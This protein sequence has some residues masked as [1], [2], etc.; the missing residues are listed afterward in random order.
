MITMP[1][2]TAGKTV[3]FINESLEIC[4]FSQLP[5]DIVSVTLVENSTLNFI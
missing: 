2:T 5:A 4:P 1:A 3:L